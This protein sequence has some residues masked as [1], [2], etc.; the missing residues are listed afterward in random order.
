MATEGLHQ[1]SQS[2]PDVDAD[3]HRGAFLEQ[4]D[5]SGAAA[6]GAV[7]AAELLVGLGAMGAWFV[8]FAGGVLIGTGSHRTAV[9]NPPGIFDWL[10]S[11]MVVL[12]F[13]T[14]TNVGLLSCI[15]AF[16]GALGRRTR[17]TVA[18]LT[19]DSIDV[20]STAPKTVATYY[21]SAV[22]RGFGIYA[23][24]FAG[25]LVLATQTFQNPEQGEYLR[26]A[27]TLSILS[28]YAG[29]DPETFAG[30]L[31]RVKQFFQ[32]KTRDQ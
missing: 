22:M 19:A 20:P 8:L 18:A 24:S 28:F 17:F 15:A 26:L 16:L 3:D 1:T 27:A 9:A 5:G 11:F 2:Q 30:L 21:V 23:L 4:F 13:W 29:Y 7:G 6:G 14:I 25:L 10:W 31:D 32:L 12:L